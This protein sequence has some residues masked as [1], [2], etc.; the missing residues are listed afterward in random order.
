MFR[1]P[2]DGFFPDF[3]RAQNMVRVIEGKIIENDLR[4]NKNIG[5]SKREFE[6]SKVR[7]T[8]CKITVNV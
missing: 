3:L 7:V 6:L 5:S 8:E 1:T 2:V 4:G